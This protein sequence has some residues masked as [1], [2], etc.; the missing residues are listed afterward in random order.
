M[1]EPIATQLLQIYTESNKNNDYEHEDI[2]WVFKY[3]KWIKILAIKKLTL[4]TVQLLFM[5][6]YYIADR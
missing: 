3:L 6:M 2:Y 4:L 1:K 5:Q